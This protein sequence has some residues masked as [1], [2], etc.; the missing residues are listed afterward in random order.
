MRYLRKEILLAILVSIIVL[1]LNPAALDAEILEDQIIF[2]NGDISRGQILE[3]TGTNVTLV[4]GDLET[5]TFQVSDI[6]R[7]TR[8][9]IGVKSPTKAF[10][11]SLPLVSGIGQWY[12]GEKLKGWGF[13]L[14]SYVSLTV[15]MGDT[16]DGGSLST[17]SKVLLSSWAVSMV[18]GAYDAHRSAK[19]INRERFGPLYESG[20]PNFSLRLMP[21]L[22]N[23]SRGL[24]LQLSTAF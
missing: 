8:E 22:S 11:L 9:P 17:S 18:A 20:E 7:M 10:A 23:N 3:Q 12:N 13:F 4:G 15:S 6:L 14:W 21:R 19:R 16:S 24:T 2:R 5:R 1:L